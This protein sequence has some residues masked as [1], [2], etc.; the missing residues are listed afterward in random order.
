MREVDFNWLRNTLPVLEFH[1]TR[2]D[3]QPIGY[4]QRLQLLRALQMR[5]SEMP[6]TWYN[7]KPI[8]A[9]S[10]YGAPG[11]PGILG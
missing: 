11:S 4:S 8:I 6:A 7:G 9:G 3:Q 2:R 10:A 5:E 1:F